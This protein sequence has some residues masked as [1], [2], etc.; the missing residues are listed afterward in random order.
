MS[1]ARQSYRTLTT[2]QYFT[3]ILLAGIAAC[4][5][6]AYA[7]GMLQKGSAAHEGKTCVRIE[8]RS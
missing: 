4:G 1:D 2:R 7:A 6:L 8:Q 3:N 5:D